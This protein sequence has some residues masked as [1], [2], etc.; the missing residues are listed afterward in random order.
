MSEAQKFPIVDGPSSRYFELFREVHLTLEIPRGVTSV[1]FVFVDK[2]LENHVWLFTAKV[3][4]KEF[5]SG[6]VQGE[7]DPGSRTG[8]VTTV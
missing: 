7:Y 2:K 6:E 5:A 1:R 4:C 8:F 3:S